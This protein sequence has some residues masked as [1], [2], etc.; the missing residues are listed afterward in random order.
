MFEF[1]NFSQFS[2]KLKNYNNKNKEILLFNFSFEDK[3]LKKRKP[4]IFLEI[5]FLII[6][7]YRISLVLT[8]YF[9]L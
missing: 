1:C 5:F 3:N 2:Q 9:N 4:I 6:Y 8:F 7:I